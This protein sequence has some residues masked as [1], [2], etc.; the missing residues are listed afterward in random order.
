MSH[1]LFVVAFGILT[2]PG[3]ALFGM[4]PV[5]QPSSATTANSDQPSGNKRLLKASDLQFVG[6]MLL[7][8]EIDPNAYGALALRKGAD[9]TKTFFCVGKTTFGTNAFEFT[10]A[11]FGPDVKGAPRAKLVKAWDIYQGHRTSTTTKLETQGLCWLGDKLFWTYGG[12]YDVQ[13]GNKPF[14]GFTRFNADG[15]ATAFGPWLLDVGQ[16]RGRNYVTILPEWFANQYT[17]GRRLAVGAGI[18]SGSSNSSW[19]P[20]LYAIDMPGEATPAGALLHSVPLVFYPQTQRLIRPPDYDVLNERE[21]VLTT[22]SPL[23]W[24][25]QGNLGYWTAAD[26]VPSCTWI[27]GRT[28]R[29]VLFGN[30]FASEHVWYGKSPLAS[31]IKDP[32]HEA[33]G[34]H[35][36][37]YR[38]AWLIYDANDLAAVAAGRM[39][40]SKIGPTEEFDPTKLAPNMQLTCDKVCTGLV[41]DAGEGM[42]Y[43]ICPRVERLGSGPY[44]VVYQWKVP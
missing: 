5:E 40:S 23:F 41:F 1:R 12:N 8:T 6:A 42:L 27:E 25:T 13:P 4:H 36:S 16:A 26:Y 9:G 33:K 30:R 29:G 11:G 21:Q 17:G 18:E 14:L 37:Q 3:A 20:G 34:Q 2:V 43:A 32:C 22:R 35:G 7:P 19:G 24:P 10:D 39:A 31:G 38:A 28:V 15:T 44:P